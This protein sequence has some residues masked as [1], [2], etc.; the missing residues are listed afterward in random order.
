MSK[1][2]AASSGYLR[3]TYLNEARANIGDATGLPAATAAGN[4]VLHVHTTPGP[5]E[6]GTSSTNRATLSG[7]GLVMARSAVEFSE[8]AEVVANVLAKEFPANAGASEDLTHWSLSHQLT[9]VIEHYGTIT[10]GPDTVP[11]G[12]VYRFPAGSLTISED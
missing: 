9:G 5:G 10:G 12:Q 7:A 1:S 3:Q 8:A 2:D 4:M 6:T 11:P